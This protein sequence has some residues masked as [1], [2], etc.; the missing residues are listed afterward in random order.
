[1]AIV[2]NIS[3]GGA[4]GRSPAV[5]SSTVT[6]PVRNGCERML[7][8]AALPLPKVAQSEERW[9]A[10][11]EGIRS[12]NSESLARLYDETCGILYGLALRVLNDPADAEEVMLDVY[13]H[14]WKSPH[15]FDASRGS[16]WAWLTV[17]TRSR[18]IDKLR[19]RGARRTRELPLDSGWEAPSV[20]PMPDSESM[21]AQERKLVRQALGTLAPEQREAI[22]L[23]FFRGLTHVE[24]A[25]AL[26]TPLG[27]IKTRIR[28]GM[29]KLREALAPTP[30]KAAYREDES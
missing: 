9:R 25:D 3:T 28:I 23:A 30:Y 18:A 15:T 24:V 6:C 29:R 17:L 10:H 27:T 1:M 19:R 12:G 8:P 4:F 20:S 22:E 2:V 26:G 11:L 16:V 21:F 14:I 13:Q 5:L 7:G